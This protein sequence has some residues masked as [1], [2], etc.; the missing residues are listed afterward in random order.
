MGLNG[1][2]PRERASPCRPAALASGQEGH[3]AG[4]ETEAGRGAASRA[5][6][7]SRRAEGPR[8]STT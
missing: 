6:A 7:E 2:E 4:R 5:R 1:G 8:R 3:F